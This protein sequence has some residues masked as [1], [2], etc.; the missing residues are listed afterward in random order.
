MTG[1]N[2]KFNL[3]NFLSLSWERGEG[4]P[5]VGYLDIWRGMVLKFS[6]RKVGFLF[7]L[8]GV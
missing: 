1:P 2:I 7:A 5:Y 3:C 8:F 6:V 4:L